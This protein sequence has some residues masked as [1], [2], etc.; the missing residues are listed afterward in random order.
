MSEQGTGP[1]LDSSLDELQLKLVCQVGSVELSLAQL[2]EL[3]VGSVLALAPRMHEGVD[4]MINGRRVGQGQ[5]VKIGDGLGV[6]LLSFA[7]S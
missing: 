4:L 1:S 3:G 7:A 6:R 5:L 2:R